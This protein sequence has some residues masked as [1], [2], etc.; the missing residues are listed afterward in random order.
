MASETFDELPEVEWVQGGECFRDDELEEAGDSDNWVEDGF[1]YTLAQNIAQLINECHARYDYILRARPSFAFGLGTGDTTA[2]AI[3]ALAD[4]AIQTF[5]PGLFS[6]PVQTSG[7]FASLPYLTRYLRARGGWTPPAPGMGED[8]ETE[9]T[10]TVTTFEGTT[11]ISGGEHEGTYASYHFNVQ[12]NGGAQLLSP[13]PTIQRKVFTVAEGLEVEFRFYDVSMVHT[14]TPSLAG[15]V[16]LGPSV[17]GE[18]QWTIKAFT[19]I[20]RTPYE[21]AYVLLNQLMDY[22]EDMALGNDDATWDFGAGDVAAVV[23]WADVWNQEASPPVPPYSLKSVHYDTD[24]ADQATAWE[25]ERWVPFTPGSNHSDRLGMNSGFQQVRRVLN[26]HRLA[27]VAAGGDDLD[28]VY[29]GCQVFSDSRSGG[30]F[31]PGGFN[32]IAHPGWWF[33]EEVESDPGEW[34]V[35]LNEDAVNVASSSGATIDQTN[36]AYAADRLFGLRLLSPSPPFDASEDY[37]VRYWQ[38]R[39]YI[40]LLHVHNDSATEFAVVRISLACTEPTALVFDAGE[41][42]DDSGADLVQGYFGLWGDAGDGVI[43]DLAAVGGD[44]IIDFLQEPGNELMDLFTG[45]QLIGPEGGDYIFVLGPLESRGFL[46]VIHPEPTDLTT[47]A[48]RPETNLPDP[49]DHLES[50]TRAAQYQHRI[51][52]EPFA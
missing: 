45:P 4:N 50:A 49:G 18:R 30:P 27:F 5:S 23:R 13:S 2:A 31:V 21:I 24:N 17:Y 28:M 34:P 48:W 52:A 33:G 15:P 37:L 1:T 35:A 19:E 46:H 39:K 10:F 36:T 9:A 22:L 6:R 7:S 47:A 26:D 42:Q 8:P 3:A 32:N 51:I 25:V 12:K 40:F 16:Y 38:N 11:I 29:H 43:D 14:I 41:S 44:T 20:R